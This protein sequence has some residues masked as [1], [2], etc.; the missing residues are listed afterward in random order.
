MEKSLEPQQPAITVSAPILLKTLLSVKRGLED[1]DVLDCVKKQTLPEIT[2]L[3]RQ[4][5]DEVLSPKW[6]RQ[7]RTEVDRVFDAKN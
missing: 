2:E 7:V 6:T 5:E 1:P 3:A 4:L